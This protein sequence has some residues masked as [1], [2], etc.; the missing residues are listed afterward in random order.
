MCSCLTSGRTSLL[1]KDQSKGNIASNYRPNLFTIN[2]KVIDRCNCRSDIYTFISRETANRQTFYKKRLTNW[3]SFCLNSCPS[4]ALVHFLKYLHA[5]YK[6]NHSQ[7][8]SDNQL[9]KTTNAGSNQAN[10]YTIVTV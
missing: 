4:D 10:F 9:Y 1:Q 6:K 7:T 3:D 8:C 2:V 5:P